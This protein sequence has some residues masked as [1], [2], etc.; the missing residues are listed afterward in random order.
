MAH[1][2]MSRNIAN[3]HD[4]AHN[5]E[6]IRDPASQHNYIGMKT[7]IKLAIEKY[8]PYTDSFL[9]RTKRTY[10]YTQHKVLCAQIN[11]RISV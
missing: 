3:A 9:L 6:R 4:H 2:Q 1:V 7:A 11:T 5:A 8:I 10:E